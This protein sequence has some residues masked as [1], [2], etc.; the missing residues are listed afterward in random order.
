MISPKELMFWLPETC[1]L[2]TSGYDG[3]LGLEFEGIE[4]SL[5][6]IRIG[7]DNL[8]RFLEELQ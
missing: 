3:Y 8:K 5:L 1:L 6:G 7:L 2:Y 4:D